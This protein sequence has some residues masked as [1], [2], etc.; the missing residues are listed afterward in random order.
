MPSHPHAS[1]RRSTESH[2]IGAELSHRQGC[3]PRPE[4]HPSIASTPSFLWDDSTN[5]WRH[6]EPPPRCRVPFEARPPWAPV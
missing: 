6:E 2:P 3:C 5:Q 1:A 4:L